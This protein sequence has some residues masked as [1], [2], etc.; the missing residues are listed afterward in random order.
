MNN[1]F[2]TNCT[3]FGLESLIVEFESNKDELINLFNKLEYVNILSDNIAEV[4]K[5]IKK[6]KKLLAFQII[7]KP[8]NYIPLDQLYHVGTSSIDTPRYQQAFGNSYYYSGMMHKG[9][10]MV[11]QLEIFMNWCKLFTP[12]LNGCLVNWYWGGDSYIGPHSDNT[13]PLLND[14]EIYTISLG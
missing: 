6:I 12:T 7:I 11:P 5:F 4:D 2:S 9:A 8:M 13:A 14:S 10:P 3:S 1:R